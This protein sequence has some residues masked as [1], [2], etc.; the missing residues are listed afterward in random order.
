MP[1]FS[2]FRCYKI[3][4]VHIVVVFLVQHLA[5]MQIIRIRYHLIIHRHHTD[6][7]NTFISGVRQN[8]P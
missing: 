1:D 7:Q 3:R 4:D 5:D 8:Y 2:T 6:H